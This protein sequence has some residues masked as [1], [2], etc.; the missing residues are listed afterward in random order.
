M[1]AKKVAKTGPEILCQTENTASG[2]A[3]IGSI[4][5]LAARPAAY[6]AA[7]PEFC[8][9]ISIAKVFF[10]CVFIL[11]TTPNRYPKA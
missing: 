10:C 5:D 3:A 11:K 1:L 4:N 7:R 8:I 2:T 6:D 9:P